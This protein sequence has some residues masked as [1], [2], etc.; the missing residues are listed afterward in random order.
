MSRGH[1]WAGEMSRGHVWGGPLDDCHPPHPPSGFQPNG[2]CPCFTLYGCLPV[3]NAPLHQ[4]LADIAARLDPTRPYVDTSPS[5]GIWGGGNGTPGPGGA[6]P[7][8]RWG[9]PQDPRYGDI[10]FYNYTCVC[11]EWGGEEWLCVCVCWRVCVT[12]CCQH[13]CEHV[14]ANIL[15]SCHLPCDLKMPYDSN[16]RTCILPLHYNLEH[17]T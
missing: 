3:V 10:H 2:R 16:S 1:V 6:L 8:R 17:T 14:L 13:V 5:N 11:M 7:L 4:R 9:D 12:A 15:P